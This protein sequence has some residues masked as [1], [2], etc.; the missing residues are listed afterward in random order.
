MWVR[1]FGQWEAALTMAGGSFLS[2]STPLGGGAVAFPVLTKVLE[3]PA[4]L[5]RTFGLSVQAVGMT[6]AVL[7]VVA[8]GGRLH[9]PALRVAVPSSVAGLVAGLW[10]M[11][12]PGAALWPPLFAT[13]WVKAAVTVALSTVALFMV[14]R[15]RHP[16]TQVEVPWGTAGRLAV[17]A[18]ALV[19]GVL[20]AVAGTG[21]NLAVFVVLVVVLGVD[22][23]RALPTSVAVM[24]TVSV[25]GL[26]VV[27]LID[28]QLDVV[29]VGDRVVA[30][31]GD[32]VGL[33]SARA[34]VVA[35][36]LAALPVVMWGAPLGAWVASRVDERALVGAVAALATVE[37]VSTFAVVEDLRGSASMLAATISG[38]VVVPSVVVAL[39]A[40]WGTGRV[41]VRTGSG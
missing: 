14:G 32:P 22:V 36:W 19:G 10:L 26:V 18:A 12:D 6:M 8:R 40:R 25:V 29:V 38:I 23:R 16:G 28:G 33:P 34:D 39:R 30:V 31:G 17:G 2:G 21:A 7:S 1:V 13:A 37:V 20:S 41:S 24:A 9:G 27:G 11:G 35:M 3:V 15:L 4:P 5:A